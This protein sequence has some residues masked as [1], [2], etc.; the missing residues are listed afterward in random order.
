QVPVAI[1]VTRGHQP[2]ASIDLQRG[3]VFEGPIGSAQQDGNV[4]GDGVGGRDIEVPIVIEVAVDDA[5]GLGA[6]VVIYG[7]LE[8]AVAVAQH[9]ADG[10]REVVADSQVR[11]TVV[12]VI[13]HCQDAGAAA[14][15]GRE[16]NRGL[17]SAV[18]VVPQ[19]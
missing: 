7:C 12:I 13:A 8:G 14:N 10:G 15:A 18:A 2:G 3:G 11:L 16:I 19:Q 1:Y 6:H 9:D 4:V 5:D 17:E